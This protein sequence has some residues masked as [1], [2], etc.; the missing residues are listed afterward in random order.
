MVPRVSMIPKHSYFNLLNLH[1]KLAAIK[2]RGHDEKAE[3]I[4]V[5]IS[6]GDL[7]G[8]EANYFKPSR[9]LEC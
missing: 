8:I 9:I 2:N 4:I 6:I 5:G 7:N 1:S 3:N